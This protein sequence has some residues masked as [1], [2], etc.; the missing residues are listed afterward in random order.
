M[1]YS[2]KEHIEEALEEVLEDGAP[3]PELDLINAAQ[4]A[5]Q[6]CFICGE[7]AEYNVN[8]GKTS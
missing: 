8:E 2:C 3:P 6:V 1:V 5:E 4:A 7:R